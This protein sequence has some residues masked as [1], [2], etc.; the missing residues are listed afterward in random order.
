MRTWAEDASQEGRRAGYHCV[1]PPFVKCFTEYLRAAGYFCTNNNKTDYQFHPPFTAWDQCKPGAHWRHRSGNQPF[2][3]VFNPMATHESGMWAEKGADTIT[4]PQQVRVPPYLV[5]GPETRKAIARQYDNLE[6][7]DR[8]VGE[9]L[10]Q[11]EEDG[12]VENT[13]VMVWS[14]HGEGLP[15]CKRWPYEGGLRV[16]LLVR[17]PGEI[18]P[19]EVSDELISTID[20]G[21]TLLTLAGV[22]LPL[23]LQGQPFLGEGSSSRDAVFATRDRFGGFYDCVRSVRDSRWRYVRNFHPEETQALWNNYLNRHPASQELWAAAR[24]RTLSP[25]QAIHFRRC[26]PPEELYDL[27][28]DPDECRNVAAELSHSETLKRLRRKLEEW[29]REIGDLYRE[30]EYQMAERFW[31]GGK[32]PLTDRP[33]WV[34][35]DDTHQGVVPGDGASIGLTSPCLIQLH[36]PTQGSSIGYR[37]EDDPPAAWR[38]YT[39]PFPLT[40]GRHRLSAKAIRIGFEESE[41]ITAEVYVE[42]AESF[43][44][45]EKLA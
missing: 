12:L 22:P 39:G 30:P 4:D 7:C 25:E 43:P 15:R 21:P 20:L 13:V 45:E 31:P 10:R 33:C 5:D 34:V 9:I 40:Q 8:M 2:F 19:G 36:A 28:S 23:H 14:D 1:P 17:W 3:A 26:R 16:P 24:R 38:L 37:F 27:D 44:D 29:Q 32:R 42:G 35:Y 41:S 18:A 6:K 11:L